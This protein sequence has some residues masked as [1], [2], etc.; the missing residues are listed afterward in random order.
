MS[1]TRWTSL[2]EIYS[3][4]DGDLT[5]DDGDVRREVGNVKQG[6]RERNVRNVLKAAERRLEVERDPTREG[7]YRL[8]EAQVSFE[9]GRGYNRGG[10]LHVR[11]GGF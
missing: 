1:S 2:Q 6:A 11:F 8:R 9:I 4:V 10:E 5:F 3:R 7:F